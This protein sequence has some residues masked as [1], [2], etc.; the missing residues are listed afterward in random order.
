[1]TWNNF[2]K[3]TKCVDCEIN[4]VKS[5]FLYN[6]SVEPYTPRDA[7]CDQCWKK[8]NK[9]P[10]ILNQQY[11]LK[12]IWTDC[13]TDGCNHPALKKFIYT[14]KFPSQEFKSF[15]NDY[16]CYK[17]VKPT[18]TT[19][20]PHSYGFS[21][22]GILPKSF[23]KQQNQKNYV[24][25]NRNDSK[26]LTSKQFNQIT[27]YFKPANHPDN[28]SKQDEIEYEDMS[29]EEQNRIKDEMRAILQAQG[30]LKKSKPKGEFDI[31]ECKNC[32]SP[33]YD[34]C[35]ECGEH[36]CKKNKCLV[37]C[38]DSDNWFCDECVDEVGIFCQECGNFS[39]CEIECSICAEI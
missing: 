29:I 15:T 39:C 17:C 18:C 11:S 4:E 5:K 27:N 1:M 9:I 28:E 19:E 21:K 13:D 37:E 7:V 22:D 34:K 6:E 24:L 14:G 36:C 26:N 3:M 35:D 31:D 2:Y 16:R 32:T 30:R 10:F 12:V 33:T 38:V 23:I 8:R 25:K 20:H